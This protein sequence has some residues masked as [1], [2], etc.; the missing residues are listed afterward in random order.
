M[1]KFTNATLNAEDLQMIYDALDILS[2]DSDAG[3]EERNYLMQ[4]V[5]ELQGKFGEETA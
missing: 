3:Q 5:A 1:P 2:P 4:Y